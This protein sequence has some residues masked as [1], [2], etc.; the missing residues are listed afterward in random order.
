MECQGLKY[1]ARRKGEQ[2]G[3]KRSITCNHKA[4]NVSSIEPVSIKGGHDA[5]NVGVLTTYQ[6]FHI[7]D[8]LMLKML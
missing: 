8:R 7:I 3:V 6:F 5:Q 2:H 4:E 1:K